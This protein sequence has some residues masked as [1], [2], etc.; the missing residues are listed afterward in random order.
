MVRS[1]KITSK[2][3]TAMAAKLGAAYDTSRATR[4]VAGVS[5]L[6]LRFGR[7]RASTIAA[8]ARDAA[9]AHVGM[10]AMRKKGILTQLREGVTHE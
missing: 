6:A 7:C 5:R 2:G 10:T 3:L 4:A 8:L 9:P 1:L